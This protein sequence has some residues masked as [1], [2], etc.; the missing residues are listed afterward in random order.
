MRLD[1]RNCRGKKAGYLEIKNENEDAR[2]LF[3]YGDI[4]SDDFGKWSEDDVCPADIREFLKGLED[5]SRLNIFINSGGGSV[6]AGL[7]IYNQLKRLKAEKIVTVDGL[8]GSIASVIM[9]AGDSVIVPENSY[10][11]IHKPEVAL[12]GSFNALSLRKRADTLDRIEESIVGVYMEHCKVSEDTLRGMMADETWLIGEEAAKVFDIVLGESFQAAACV[13]DFFEDY[14][15]VP[16]CFKSARAV[17]ERD[18][19]T[20]ALIERVN[21]LILFEKEL[22]YNE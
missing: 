12:L 19:E 22:I 8:A 14:K 13:S 10:I 21:N 9:F 3:I 5:A 15:C 2:D 18:E 11:M 17:P 7:A 16:E 1:F 20:E 6:F 4:V